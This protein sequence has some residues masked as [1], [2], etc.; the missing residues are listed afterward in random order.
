[1][2]KY[3]RFLAIGLVAL[4]LMLSGCGTQLYELTA[5]EEELI[6]KYAAHFVAKHNIYQ[7]DG[8]TGVD[9]DA[10]EEESE[11]SADSETQSPDNTQLPSGSGDGNGTEEPDD[12][13]ISIADAIGL[14]DGL[15]LTYTG[16]SITNYV[17]EGEGYSVDAGEGFTFY[18]MTFSLENTTE[19]DIAEDN[20]STHPVFKMTSGSI[21]TKSSV[22]FLSADLST[23]TNTISA[24]E[25]VETILLFKINAS[26][27]EKVT[28]PVLQIT[29]DGETKN[30]K[31]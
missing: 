3:R 5:E 15:I 18:V 1:M 22:S 31:L 25:T 21:A 4:S 11:E 8:I 7:K 14:P 9:A 13:T 27:A 29:I 16:N 26:D 20:A 6:V 12:D 19:Q 24:G 10:V 17:M 23:Y 28:N 30:V 2:K